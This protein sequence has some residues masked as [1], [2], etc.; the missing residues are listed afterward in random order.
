MSDN[1][2]EKSKAARKA[3]IEA[4][5]DIC[6]EC[7]DQHENLRCNEIGHVLSCIKTEKLA[8]KI[9]ADKLK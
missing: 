7:C 6:V 1:Y 2:L 9:F 4:C 3:A 5:E 8:N